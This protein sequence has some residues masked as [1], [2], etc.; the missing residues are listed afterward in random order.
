MEQNLNDFMVDIGELGW[1]WEYNL[2]PNFL[3]DDCGESA[4]YFDDDDDNISDLCSSRL[5]TRNNMGEYFAPGCRN[6]LAS[7]QFS[8]GHPMLGT[9]LSLKTVA[10]L[11]ELDRV[12]TPPDFRNEK[13]GLQN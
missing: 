10:L 1:G 6:D 13:V 4:G 9:N 3:M 11:Q 8:I 12:L 5:V 2:Q 7:F